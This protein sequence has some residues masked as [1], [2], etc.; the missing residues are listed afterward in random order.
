LKLNGYRIL[1][2]GDDRATRHTAADMHRIMGL[3]YLLCLILV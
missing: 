2:A 3:R 1:I